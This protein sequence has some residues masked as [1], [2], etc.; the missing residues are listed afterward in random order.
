MKY[1]RINPFDIAN[2]P[3]VRVAIWFSGCELKCKGC[4]NEIAQDPDKGIEFTEET[5]NKIIEYL[6]SSNIEGLSLLGGD[7]L[8]KSN[9]KKVTEFVKKVREKFGSEKTIWLWTGYKFEYI[10]DYEILKYVDVV[11]DGPFIESL[12]NIKLKYSGS[13]NQRV[14]DVEKSFKEERVVLY[15]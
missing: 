4:F 7:P 2:G 6:S 1:Q 9:I 10:I 11:V 3:G 12:K 14:I 5:E 8:Y 15:E 13:E